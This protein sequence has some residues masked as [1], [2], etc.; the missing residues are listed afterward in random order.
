MQVRADKYQIARAGEHYVVAELSR[1]G[2]HAV[3]F[4]GNMPGIDVMASDQ[5][6]SRN[7]FIQVK[8]RRRGTW[9]A[10]STDGVAAKTSAAEDHFW[11]F[12]DFGDGMGPPAFFVVPRQWMRNDIHVA[13]QKYLARHGGKRARNQASTHHGIPMKRIAEWRDRWDLL[14][15]F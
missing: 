7:V 2:A 9:H 1:R 6:R 10:R 3:T 15:L 5:S 11:V 13:H 4:A 8:S 12:V 14:K